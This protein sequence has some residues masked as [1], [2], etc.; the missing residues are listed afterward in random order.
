MVFDFLDMSYVS[1]DLTDSNQ[2][3][4]Y[5]HVFRPNH[6]VLGD[7][8]CNKQTNTKNNMLKIKLNQTTPNKTLI[9]LPSATIVQLSASSSSLLHHVGM[10]TG[11]VFEG[12]FRQPC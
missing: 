4:L 10:S 8:P 12:I 11:V 1:Q 9:I 2:R 6:I 3:C 5:W 7:H